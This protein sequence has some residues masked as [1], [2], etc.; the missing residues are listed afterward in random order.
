[1][2]QDASLLVDLDVGRVAK[3]VL[4]RNAQ[5][6]E[7]LRPVPDGVAGAA[8]QHQ[9]ARQGCLRCRPAHARPGRR[10]KRQRAGSWSATRAPRGRRA[11]LE[12][13]WSP[14]QIAAWLRAEHPDRPE[15]HL[16]H[17]TIY[18]ALYLGRNGGLSRALTAKSAPD[19]RYGSV[20]G[21]PMSAPRG[22][23]RRRCSFTA[24]PRSSRPELESATGRGLIVGRSSRSAIGTLV[25]RSSCALRLVH[26]PN[27]HC[28]DALVEAITPVLEAIPMQAGWTLTWDQCSEMARHDLVAEHFLQGVFFAEP[29]P[30][31]GQPT[32]TPT[33]CSASS[34]PRDA[35]CRSTPS[36]DLRP[37]SSSSTTGRG[38]SL[39]R[40]QARSSPPDCHDQTPVL[41]RRRN[42]LGTRPSTRG[43]FSPVA[44]TG[45]VVR[46]ARRRSCTCQSRIAVASVSHRTR[47]RAGACGRSSPGIG[48][49]GDGR[50]SHERATDEFCNR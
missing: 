21:R 19:D 44:D 34:S 8:P 35:T 6:V 47:L 38:A 30:G 9:A 15:W 18:Q 41:R 11:K 42:R 3:V 48:V 14:Q 28:A 43:Q 22:S 17:E 40:L 23:S 2:A 45:S 50:S 20:A 13:T 4:A 16:C 10:A 24:G 33:V 26:L 29:V 5:E 27:G 37:P 7:V 12:D 36:R 49:E 39:S 46:R 1:M 32:R 25:C 31:S